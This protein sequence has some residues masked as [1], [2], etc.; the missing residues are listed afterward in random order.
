MAKL[1]NK[2]NSNKGIPWGGA[3]LIFFGKIK[4]VLQGFEFCLISQ[5]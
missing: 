1:A 5:K 3:T 4:W 2:E